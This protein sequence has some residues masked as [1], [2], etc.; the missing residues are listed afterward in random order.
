MTDYADL[1]FLN[2]RV[3][4]A[5]PGR[6][7]AQA[8]AVTG[9]RVAYVGNNAEAENWRGPLSRVIE[10]RGRTVMP[11]F[12][13]SHIHLLSGAEELR[14]A[15]LQE[16]RSLEAL[17]YALRTH[18]EKNPDTEWI[19]G[20]GLA[21][22]LHPLERSLTRQDL[23][24][25]LP[26]LPTLVVAYDSHTAWANTEALRRAGLLNGRNVGSFGEVVLGADGYA[27]G[28]LRE[29]A[30]IELVYDLI[31][32]PSPEE[33]HALLLRAMREAAVYGLT[34]LHNMDGDMAQLEYYSA[35]ER[36]GG[37][38]QRV[39]V[40]LTVKAEMEPGALSEAVEMREKYRGGMVRGGLTKFFLDGVIESYT[41][42]L[43]ED[44]EGKP[45]LRGQ[46]NFEPEHFTDLALEADRLGLQM[47]VHCTGDGAVRRTLD[48]YAMARERN[49]R[50]DARHRIEHIELV[51]DADL[52]RFARL[53]VIASMQPLHRPVSSSGADLWPARVGPG[54]FRRS[55]AW[56]S[57]REAGATVAFGSDWT[58]ASMNPLAGIQAALTAAPWQEGDPDPRQTLEESLLS[59]TR[60]AAHAEF[61]ER[62]KGIL[63]PGYLADLVLLSED[64]F[65]VP[66]EEIGSAK[67]DLTV[68]DGRVTHA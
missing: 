62:E 6:P 56:R 17:A 31:P 27:T 7:R 13:D 47:A 65:E 55:F 26:E 45:G 53:G 67:V 34:S 44:Y 9:N 16:V 10:A 41:G 35:C 22:L 23:D 49:R 61:M 32:K 30:A 5:D 42:L 37:M 12:I 25:I 40:P 24:F 60:Q 68:C 43:L 19:A 21:Y 58:V 48:A 4:T 57:L 52:P 14:F 3:F 36:A 54:R 46:A 39:Y 64:I 63:R 33:K 51:S 28:E 1:L 18:I 50:K 2:A 8:V 29:G 59:Y 38:L 11:G 66:P 15:Q 20:I